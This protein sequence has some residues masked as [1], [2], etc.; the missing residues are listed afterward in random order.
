[1]WTI[2]GSL[3]SAIVRFYPRHRSWFWPFWL[4][5]LAV[6]G[7]LGVQAWLWLKPS[8][9]PLLPD[10]AVA[11]RQTV[12]DA[13]DRFAANGGVLP[14]RAA[15][16]HLGGDPTDEATDALRGELEAREGW[17]LLEGSPVKNFLRQ[18]GRTMVDATSS[19]E[20]LRPGNRVGIDVIF[21]GRLATVSTS[22]GI[23]RASL[24]LSAYDT[25]RGAA[26]FAETFSAEYPKVRTA[27]GR[28]AMGLS[29][30][31]RLLLFAVLALALPFAAAPVVFRVAEARSNRASA[32]LLAG[33]AAVDLALVALLFYGLVDYGWTLVF[34]LFACVAYNLAVC[35][36]LARRS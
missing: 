32:A 1:M 10:Q 4:V 36:I 20:Y 6:A 19:D 7:F 21:R 3:F 16:M 9:V 27:V 35:E 29:R 12:S 17:T 5:V 2:L 8:R 26:V 25:R 15:V 18:V 33:L 31:S 30:R 24:E 22:N 34:S 23:S 11:V 14:A 13:L 28:A